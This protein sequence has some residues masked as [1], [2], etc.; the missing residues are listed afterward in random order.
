MS[1]TRRDALFQKERVL[2]EDVE[3]QQAHTPGTQ[4]A[5]SLVLPLPRSPAEANEWASKLIKKGSRVYA[6]YPETTVLYAATVTDSTTYCRG[7]DDIIVVQ[8]DEEEADL[9]TNQN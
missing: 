4:V 9:I 2:L 7:D 6:M 1:D 5:R 8:F 3:D